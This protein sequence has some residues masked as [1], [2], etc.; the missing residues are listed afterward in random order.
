[1][2]KLKKGLGTQ[3][4]NKNPKLNLQSLIKEEESEDS[5]EGKFVNFLMET[6]YY[7]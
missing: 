6:K 5:E 7:G 4:I 2:K 1:M 3:I